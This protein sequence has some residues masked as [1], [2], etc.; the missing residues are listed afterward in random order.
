MEADGRPDRPRE[1]AGG[2]PPCAASSPEVTT[3]PAAET[4]TPSKAPP[5]AGDASAAADGAAPMAV[6]APAAEEA[7]KGAKGKP[8][9]APKKA[10]PA[11]EWG[12]KLAAA[13]RVFLEEKASRRMYRLCAPRLRRRGLRRVL[14]EPRFCARDRC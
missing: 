5:P 11:G 1:D 9:A 8:R 4:E 2:T 7:P 10:A 14:R 12:D 3:P 6:D 13:H